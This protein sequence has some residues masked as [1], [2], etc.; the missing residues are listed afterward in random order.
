M[1]APKFAK[2]INKPEAGCIV[3]WVAA[4]HMGVMLDD[5]E[6]YFYSARSPEKG[7]GSA[8][9]VADINYFGSTPMYWRVN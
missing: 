2:R 9:L 3:I 4:G 8:P 1:V 5:N 7:I 6:Q